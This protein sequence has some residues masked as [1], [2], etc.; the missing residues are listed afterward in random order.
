[1]KATKYSKQREAIKIF[2]DGNHGHPTADEVYAAIRQQFP[3][4]SLGTVYRNLNQLAENG[5]IR[6]MSYVSGP[7]HFDY[8]TSQ[9]YHFICRDCGRVYD[10]PVETMELIDNA[11]R[12]HAPGEV[13]SH[14]LVFYGTCTDCLRHRSEAD[15]QPS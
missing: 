1:M 15:V 11:I 8:N 12:E 10:M 13:D 6:K 4:I 3:N 9:H 14:D 7:D 2:L 5:E